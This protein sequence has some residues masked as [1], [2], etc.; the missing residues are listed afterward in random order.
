MFGHE[1]F[2]AY[3]K[4][5]KFVAQ[6]TPIIDRLPSGNAHLKDQLK[7]ASVSIPL[8]IAEGSG[9]RSVR[10]K[11]RFYTIARGSAMECAAILDVLQALD[12]ISELEVKEPKGLLNQVTA[13]LSSICRKDD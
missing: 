7:R 5:I 1:K 9:K 6:A 2:G 12:L 10:E 3:Q 4:A 11:R 13:I 8:N